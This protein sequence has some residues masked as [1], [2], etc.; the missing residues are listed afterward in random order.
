MLSTRSSL[1]QNKD[2]IILLERHCDAK[3][4][5]VERIVQIERRDDVLNRERCSLIAKGL[6]WIQQRCFARRIPAEE[7]P[8]GSSEGKASDYGAG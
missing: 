8:H 4:R 3:V 5:A 6:D 2:N 7:N 1:S